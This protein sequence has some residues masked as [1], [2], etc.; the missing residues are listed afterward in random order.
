MTQK[1]FQLN[2][3]GLVNKKVVIIFALI[4]IFLT[5]LMVFGSLRLVAAPIDGSAKEMNFGSVQAR[6]LEDGYSWN[7]GS[8]IINGTLPNS[9]DCS[10]FGFTGVGSSGIYSA[11]RTDKPG[12]EDG[13]VQDITGAPPRGFWATCGRKTY[14]ILKPLETGAQAYSTISRDFPLGNFTGGVANAKLI[15]DYKAHTTDF[16]NNTGK[17]VLYAFIQD[18]NTGLYYK[19]KGDQGNYK[20]DGD[21]KDGG[22]D[23]DLSAWNGCDFIDAWDPNIGII[24]GPK[25]AD[26]ADSQG[27]SILGGPL[28]DAHNDR[29]FNQVCQ[30]SSSDMNPG[31]T[32]G[33]TSNPCTSYT[34]LAQFLNQGQGHTFKVFFRLYYSLQ[35]AALNGTERFSLTLDDVRIQATL[36]A[37][38]VTVAP[39]G[40]ILDKD[41]PA[42]NTFQWQP[43]T[44]DALGA[45]NA[46]YVEIKNTV[47][48]TIFD[49]QYSA[50]TLSA[51]VSPDIF[52]PGT[53][54]NWRVVVQDGV[55][56]C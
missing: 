14:N 39:A 35:V 13:E 25:C 40:N 54:Y 32:F 2:W 41:W 36:N 5:I 49:H 52:T 23:D 46:Y 7:P 51:S 3:E 50:A 16:D 55:R 48:E 18:V 20:G 15:F 10:N 19:I 6:A 28:T 21:G 34:S 8:A 27:T 1:T 38:T 56:Q 17:A 44:S 47:G 42:T 12:S 31:K 37:P 24:I 53:T 43:P 29:I 22:T 4:A 9:P 26:T 11:I 45:I 33:G 30:T